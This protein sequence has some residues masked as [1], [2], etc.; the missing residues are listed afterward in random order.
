MTRSFDVFL[1]LRLHKRL[2]K[3]SR[4]RW[5]GTP[6]DNSKFVTFCS[7]IWSD[8][9]WV[10][11]FW[12]ILE[13]QSFEPLI[14]SVAF[15]CWIRLRAWITGVMTGISHLIPYKFKP[16]TVK[17]FSYRNSSSPIKYW[18]KTAKALFHY[19][20]IYVICWLHIILRPIY[21]YKHMT[22]IH[23]PNIEDVQTI[24]PPFP[25]TSV[26]MRDIAA[27]MTSIAP[28]SKQQSI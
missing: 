28:S 26:R 9:A 7:V 20:L 11:W 27:S 3:P 16:K 17:W 12:N 22:V 4:W 5:F 10:T 8:S 23:V 25:P 6:Q 19:Q 1:D 13:T 15:Q 2:S 24:I 14:S 18:S 21:G